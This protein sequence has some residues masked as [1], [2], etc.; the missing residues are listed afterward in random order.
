LIVRDEKIC[1]QSHSQNK[2]LLL[3]TQAN[4][5]ATVEL[6]LQTANI[7]ERQ[8]KK[9][10]SIEA[11]SLVVHYFSTIQYLTG[12]EV[13]M[14]NLYLPIWRGNFLDDNDMTIPFINYRSQEFLCKPLEKHIVGIR[15]YS[16]FISE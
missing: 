16:Q 9:L 13:Q 4:S 2:K 5:K 15:W 10:I 7:N 14:F 12:V 3:E 8:W 11:L 1:R 6:R